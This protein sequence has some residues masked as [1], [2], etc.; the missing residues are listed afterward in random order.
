M[1]DIQGEGG[2]GACLA[3]EEKTQGTQLQYSP[4]HGEV[5]EK[6]IAYITSCNNGN[7][8]WTIILHCQT[9]Q[10]VSSKVVVSPPPG[11]SWMRPQA[12]SSACSASSAVWKRW[13]SMTSRCH[14]QFIFFS[15]CSD[16]YCTIFC[17]MVNFVRTVE[18]ITWHGT[19]EL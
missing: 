5:L 7:P 10:Q 18:T 6:G 1:C 2:N 15:G 17:V 4:R 11:M 3:W 8:N 19:G 13:G 16:H 14:F 9:L 12:P